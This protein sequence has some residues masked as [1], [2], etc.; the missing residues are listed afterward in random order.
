MPAA[1]MRLARAAPLAFLAMCLN[2][3]ASTVMVVFESRLTPWM[4]GAFDCIG[5]IFSLICAALAIESIITTGWRT[6]R[7]LTLI[8]VVSLANLLG[9]VTGVYIAMALTH[10]H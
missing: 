1:Q 6:K 7:S 5:W 10:H 3:C 9:T 2:D 8:A 4:A